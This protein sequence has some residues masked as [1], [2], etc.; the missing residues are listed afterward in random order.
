MGIE[1]KIY[2]LESDMRELQD[3]VDKLEEVNAELLAAYHAELQHEEAMREAMPREIR[4]LASHAFVRYATN[5]E[6]E[7]AYKSS[8]TLTLTVDGELC[9][10]L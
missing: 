4:G 5:R 6:A 9:Y 3:R 8:N 10:V 2:E 1:N 7:L